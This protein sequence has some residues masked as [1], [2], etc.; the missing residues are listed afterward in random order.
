MRQLGKEKREEA[1]SMCQSFVPQ[2][3]E[4]KIQSFETWDHEKLSSAQFVG[5]L[6]HGSHLRTISD[7]LRE[8]WRV[9]LEYFGECS[10]SEEG[11]F[12]HYEE[13]HS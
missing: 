7:Y 1:R 11:I 9:V 3:V 4:K 5:F 13:A 8:L 12:G 6:S 2:E 10:K